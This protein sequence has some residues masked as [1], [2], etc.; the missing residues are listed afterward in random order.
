MNDAV[1]FE[2]V[3][4]ATEAEQELIALKKEGA[5]I[6]KPPERYEPTDPEEI[7]EF[8]HAAFEPLTILIGVVALICLI[9]RVVLAVKNL[10]FG[11]VVIEVRTD[12]TTKIIPSPA[13]DRG[14]IVVVSPGQEAKVYESETKAIDIVKAIKA[15]FGGND[16]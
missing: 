5:S 16:T 7:D 2:W 3:M 11:G 8:A 4:F 13:L 9:E 14:T 1:K 15:F 6:E 12:G 10:K